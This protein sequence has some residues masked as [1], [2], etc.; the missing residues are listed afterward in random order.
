MKKHLLLGAF[1]LGSL[2]TANAQFTESFEGSTELPTG[3][4]VINGG[5]AAQ[6]WVIADLTGADIIA[7]DGTNIATIQYGTTA[8]DDLLITPAVDVTDGVSDVLSFWARSRDAAYPEVISVKISTTDATAAAFTTTLIAEVAPASGT[9]FYSYSYDLSAYEGETVYIAFV[10]ET[11][12]M[13]AFDLDL[14]SVSND[15]VVGC[16]VPAG[17]TVIDP[18]PTT[19]TFNIGWTAVDGVTYEVEY[20]APDFEL[21]TGDSMTA[22]TAEANFTD[23]EAGTTY[24]FYVRTDCGDGEYSAWAGPLSFTT[25]FNPTDI[26]YAYG[27]ETSARD[28]WKTANNAVDGGAWGFYIA[29]ET[30]S[31]VDGTI[32]AGVIGTAVASDSWLFSRGLNLTAGDEVTVTYW[33]R[34]AL[35][36]GAGN[37]NS[38][39]VTAGADITAEAQTIALASLADADFSTEEYT[40]ITNTFTPDADGVYYLGFHY[41]SPAHTAEENGGLLLDSVYVTSVLGTEEVTAS[42]FA[43]YPNPA[44]DVVNISANAGLNNVQIV[45]INGRTVKSVEFDG[46]N[47][48]QINISDLASGL[49]IMNIASDKGTSSQKIVKN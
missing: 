37:T 38:L 40:L 14:V 32:F 35:L 31:A 11:T 20:G 30:F 15:V 48:A 39:V 47:Q 24:Q 41:T 26:S 28:G 49:Y 7:Q 3:W 10:S 27:F 23:L 8:H 29:D 1:F 45:D 42:N 12:D 21:G 44:N 33:V 36:A 2:F 18:A 13:F 43:V 17:F 4:T 9:A 19:S 22:A 5:D 46:T 25:E 34:K 6:T 16:A